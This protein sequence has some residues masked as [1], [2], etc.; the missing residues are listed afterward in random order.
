LATA[1]ALQGF[2]VGL[3]SVAIARLFS[4]CFYALADTRTPAYTGTAAFAANLCFGLMLM[5]EVIIGAETHGAARFFASLSR[6][7]AV[8][9]FGVGG[10]ALAASLGATVNLVLLGS[11]LHRRL[12]WFPWS[13]CGSL[14]LWSLSASAIMA[15]VVRWIVQQ[16]DWL[17]PQTSFVWRLSVLALAV[18]AGI[19]SFLLVVWKGGKEELRTLTGMLPDPLL[20][21]L[22]QFL[23]PNR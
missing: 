7:F 18:A 12:G 8:Y 5:G 21:L 17:N 16:V 19:A 23:Q 15:V 10:L 9:D 14:L 11:L 13:G 6:S 20:R 4:S 22:P 2:A 3:W 1:A